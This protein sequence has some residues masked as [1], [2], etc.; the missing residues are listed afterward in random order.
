MEISDADW[1]DLIARTRR[2]ALYGVVTT[3][4]YCRY[5]CPS[6]APLRRN[7]RAFDTVQQAQAAGLR[8]CKRCIP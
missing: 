8:A 6:P 2:A 4:I 5:G 1:A 7:V 3:G